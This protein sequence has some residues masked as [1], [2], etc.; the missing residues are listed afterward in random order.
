MRLKEVLKGKL[1]EQELLSVKQAFD[2][3]GSIAIL[4]IPKELLKRQKIIAEAVMKANSHITT[5]VKKK[6]TH[7]GEF[8]IQHVSHLAGIRTK[9]TLHKENGVIVKLN[10]GKC[11]FSPRLVTE[12]KRIAEFV[13]QG[14]EV[15][16]MFS[17]VGIYCAV[18]AKNTK[19]RGIIGIEKNPAAHT[20][21]VENVR[22]NKI[23]NVQV[24]CGDVRIVVPK[25][26]KAFDR[27]LMPLPMG[28]EDYLDVALGVIRK[29]GTIHFY[30]FLHETEFPHV[31]EEKVLKACKEADRKCKIL[32]T[33]KCGDYA[34]RRWRVCVD[35][36]VN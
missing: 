2:M 5:V 10:I 28:A 16:V 22:L 32:Q 3:I 23:K 20:Y 33:V 24:Y 17:G 29:K 9:E 27:I 36:E 8:R 12:R 11:Y 30:G 35:V 21:A 6:G 26:K 14:E 15:L 31:A 19:A 4:D 1:T 25:L 7:T 18:L 34:P 13:K